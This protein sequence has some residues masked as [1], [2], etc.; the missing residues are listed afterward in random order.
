MRKLTDIF[1]PHHHHRPILFHQSKARPAWNRV[2][3]RFAVRNPN[4][5]R[6]LVILLRS[7]D[8]VLTGPSRTRAWHSPRIQRRNPSPAIV[9]SSTFSCGRQNAVYVR[10]TGKAVQSPY[11]PPQIPEEFLVGCRASASTEAVMPMVPE[12]RYVE[13]SCQWV[14]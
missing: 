13:A 4:F 12:R 6:F 1:H 11:R 3:D 9:V 10:V 14:W 8:L 2:S 7:Y 5:M